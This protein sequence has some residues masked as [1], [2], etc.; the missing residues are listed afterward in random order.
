MKTSSGGWIIAAAAA[1]AAI[2]VLDVFI[3][4]GIAVPML[5]VIPVL[6]TWLVP[7]SRITVVIASCSV[8]LT[9]LGIVV[10]PGE[11]APVVAADRAMASALQ[12]VVAGLLIIH[13]KS[14]R[15]LLTVQRLRE[16]EARFRALVEQIGDVFWISD[17][18]SR[19]LVNVS[20]KFEEI[21]KR[22]S[23]ELYDHFDAWLDAIHEDDRPRVAK[24]FFEKVL[25][26]TYE[27]E[28][29]VVR[30]DGSIR[31]IRD[32]G[33]PLGVG[34]LVAGVAEDI[35]ERKQVEAALR[36]S[37]ARFRTMADAVPSFLFET[38][39]EGW[40]IWTSPGWCR[41][42]GQTT[43]Q[44]AGHGWAEALHPDDRAANI[45]RWVQCM[46]D[47]VPFESKQRLHRV[48]GSYAW[49]IARALP[50]HDSQGKV[51]RWVGSVTDV[52]TIVRAEETLR[53]LNE[54]LEHRVAERAAALREAEERFRGIFE[55]AAEGI[56]IID[57]EG[58]FLQCNPAFCAILGYSE[59]E[60]LALQLPSL[61]HPEDRPSNLEL[62]RQ[63]ISGQLPSFEL[64]NRHIT[65]SGNYIWVHKQASILRND[66]GVPT[67]VMVLVTDITKRKHMEAALR[68]VQTRQHLLLTATPVVLYSCRITADFGTTFIS[69]N[70]R[71]QLGY[72]A[73]DFT[74]ESDF[75]LT[76]LHPDD[77]PR[78]IANLTQALKQ[79]QQV[80]E[81]R[82]LH[83]DGT[84]RWL[85]DESRLIRD[86][87]GV[88][89]EI[90]GF[91]I[92]ITERKQAEDL[93]SQQQA[94]LEDLTAKLLIAQETER[95]RIA[96]D[97]HDDITQR[98]AAVAIELQSIRQIT[99]GAEASVVACVQ[100]SGQMVEQIAM[101]L[102][103]LARQLHPSLLEHVGLE[104][105]VQEHAEEFEIRTGLRTVVV[106]RNPPAA[107]SLDRAT[108]LFRVL[109]E[110]L[111]NVSKHANATNVLVQLLGTRQ[112]VGLCVHDD[113]RGFDHLSQ[114]TEKL[115]G[116]GL[117][118][119]EERIEALKGTF[120]VKTKPGDGTELH[121]WIPLEPHEASN[122]REAGAG[123]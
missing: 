94:K 91:Q 42:T 62:V 113:G 28:Y 8:A 23:K 75:W 45:D 10:S 64:E 18:T 89:L 41:F 11:F 29:R 7:G 106:V 111:Q 114:S 32:R 54:T 61:I 102:Q 46:K 19:K 67:H 52:D 4:L 96:R 101:D 82:F 25:A 5:Y 35:T 95:Q 86:P 34:S 49:V 116:L 117:I 69:E 77:R 92:D 3:P 21:W 87:D 88:P 48:D 112:G 107:L 72:S 55:H 79:K 16:S 39:A 121:A 59:K 1:A 108:C 65:K 44:V 15:Q 68:T 26:G 14:T 71:E 120:R 47:G 6:L 17:P 93:L 99:P 80:Q 43:E 98:I 13:K 81:Y 31:W 12:L 97:L 24:D 123:P 109:Q 22:S 51:T 84:Y 73:Q 53:R 63:L 110:S 85:H 56:A 30:P 50:V 70:V 40:N 76:H 57:W 38:D 83:H 2:F 9:V 74:D 118:S 104:A 27:A 115:K 78:V 20:P 105:A 122:E 100:R 103:H 58:R 90:V 119:M 60:L 37:E 66:Q 33:K 36:E